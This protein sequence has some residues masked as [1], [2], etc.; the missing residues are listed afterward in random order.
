MIDPITVERIQSAARIEEVIGDYITLRKRG[1]NYVGLC[2]FHEDKTPSFY[3]SPSKNICKCFSCGEGGTPIHF[4][5]KHEQL[6][7]VE[8]LKYL[9]KKYGIEV[10]EQE[11][12][13]EQK[14][15]HSD[16]ESLFIINAYAQKIF[17]NNLLNHLEGKSVALSYFK[18]RG[19]REDIIDK[20]QLGYALE[21]K[22]AF[23]QGAINAGYKLPYL[24]K[25]GLSIVGDNNYLADRFR[26][27]VLFPVHSLSGKI[28]AFG[29]RTLKKEDKIAK[30]INSPESEIYHKGNELYGIYFA[31]QAMVKHDK[32]FLVEGYTDVIS[33]HQAGI[34]NVVAS[35]GTALTQ[36][37]IRLVHRFT[38][39]ITILYDGDA[40]GIKAALRGID[41]LLEE[42][43]N[44][45]VVL[46]PP[47]E[48]P[49]SFAKKQNAESLIGYIKHEETDFVRF[50][51]KLLMDEAGEDPIKRAQLITE[52]VNTIAII[53]EE[54]IRSVYNKDCARLFEMDESILM[55]AIIKKR[56]EVAKSPKA[57]V[58][59]KV[60]TAAKN[61]NIIAPNTQPS[62]EKPPF[63]SEK[64]PATTA[65]KEFIYDAIELS[66]LRFVVRYGELILYIQQDEDT[67][68]EV[69]VHVVEHIFADLQND[70]LEFLNPLYKTMLAE[71]FE[72]CKDE[73]FIAER[74]F[75]QHP[76]PEI[77]MLAVDLV[78]DK[79]TL[80]K[81]HSK[82]KKLEEESEKLLETIPYLMLVY[83]DA[84]LK[85]AIKQL[86]L[87]IKNVQAEASMDELMLLMKQLS[88]LKETQML[89]S[90][91]AGERIILRM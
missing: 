1:V 47:G 11:L 13:T 54:I 8:A 5:M 19:F 16:R 7:Y 62:A 77:S 2:P 82:F 23:T 86:S 34:E 32:C 4:M 76:N 29:G 52:I 50:K 51:A 48:D 79:Y 60:Q 42:G 88:E 72:K 55:N 28:V 81:V 80:S 53:P 24:E 66:I 63:E 38:D 71:A 91:H 74:Y 37:Q 70:Q 17:A 87:R 68:E 27:R 43:M 33:M 12:S 58:S 78:S 36:G 85:E 61:T 35:S 6:T 84:V 41:L 57:L 69:P 46:L 44:I 10:H 45:K 83:K 67:K 39:N 73:G 26:G 56:R 18:A 49:D 25:T 75:L 30:Y 20:F 90:K 15:R 40:A 31:R 3:V 65:A 21:Q 14:Q 22:D 64:E 9:A 89:I 59:S